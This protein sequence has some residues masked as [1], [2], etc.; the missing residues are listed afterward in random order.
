MAGDDVTALARRRVRERTHRLVASHYPTVGVF[1][2]LT[3]EPEDL[4]IALL[5]ASAT[6][7]LVANPARRIALLPDDDI[8]QGPTA[9]LVMAAFLHADPAGGRFSD[10]RLGAWYAALDVL[11]AIAETLYH[12]GRRLRLSDGA[13]PSSIQVREL[14]AGIDCELIDIRGIGSAR[15]ELYDP[16]DYSA[17]Q[18]FGTGLRWPP[19]GRGEGGIIYDSVRRADGTNVCLWRPQLVERPVTQGDHYLYQWD[20]AGTA[21][22]NKLTN[23]D[24]RELG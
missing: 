3:D 1:D 8:V 22:V 15:P 11:T 19:R 18:A 10:A 21:F 17:S 7:D 12:S 13:F 2:D 9:S 20:A 16:D 5:L 24:I 6:D 14:I 23:I 4:R